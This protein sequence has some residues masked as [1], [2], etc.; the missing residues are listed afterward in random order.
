MAKVIKLSDLE[1]S[2]YSMAEVAELLGFKNN[3][4]LYCF[5]RQYN[6]VK[7]IQPAREFLIVDYFECCQKE[8]RNKEGRTF[9]LVPF[10]R[11]TRKGVLFISE[12]HQLLT[13]DFY[14]SAFTK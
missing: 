8:V 13:K 11:V 4:T 10:T 3:R 1:K 12:L 2:S 5:L 7:G 14:V 9:K 6:I